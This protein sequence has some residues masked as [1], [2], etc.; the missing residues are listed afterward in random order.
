MKDRIKILIADDESDVIEFLSFNLI[1]AGYDVIT[2]NNGS[3]AVRLSLEAQP[4]IIL[5][6]IMMP[7]KD[8]LQACREIRQHKELNNTSIIFLTAREEEEIQIEAFDNGANDFISKPIRINVF[9]SRIKALANRII[10]NNAPLIEFGD[11]EINT[12]NFSVKKNNIDLVLPRKEF[13][14]LQLLASKPGKLFS[15]EEILNEIWGADVIVGDRTIDV[16]VSKLR[17]KVGEKYI[18]TL[19]GLG[20]KLE[21]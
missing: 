18:K 14:I 19:K 7:V 6:D 20:Y 1:N 12:E 8:G 15:R 5:L 9:L 17:E 3:D 2:A 4:H 13:R 21:Y 11:I 16:H 10:G